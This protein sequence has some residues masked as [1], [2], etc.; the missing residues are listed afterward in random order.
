MHTPS[1]SLARALLAVFSLVFSMVTYAQ[2]AGT[3]NLTV[4][5]GSGAG[6]VTPTATWSTTP[7]AIA[8][9]A[10]GGWSGNKAVSGT[11]ALPAITSSADFTLTCSWSGGLGSAMVAWSPPTTNTDNSALEDLSG[12]TIIYGTSATA[13]SQSK[14]VADPTA[15]TA[16]VTGLSPG[17]WFFAVRAYNAV[18]NPSA[19]G[20]VATKTIAGP[21]AAT[22]A[23]T[24]HVDV[25][26]VPSP[27][28]GVT[29]QEIVAYNVVPNLQRF[30]F[31]R[32]SRAGKAKLGAACDERRCLEEAYCVVARRSQVTPQPPAGVP[33]VAKCG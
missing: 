3:V 5:P 14:L 13:L 31:E 27:P 4:T 22:A 23:R 10:S 9:V 30:A 18:G 19:P 24:A 15:K 29:V 11:Q 2:T 25:S 8:C 12:F 6:S 20:N 33:V 26:K 28:T 16:P 21:P 7:A 17:T 32:G 1:R